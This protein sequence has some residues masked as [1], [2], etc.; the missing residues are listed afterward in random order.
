MILPAFGIVSHIIST[1]SRKELFGYSSMVW[2]MEKIA[3]FNKFDA[4]N[5]SDDGINF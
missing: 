2:A 3:G 1:F 4:R 5:V